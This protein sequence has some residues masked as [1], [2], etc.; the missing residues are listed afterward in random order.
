MK[1]FILTGLLALALT[2][3]GVKTQ[4]LIVEGSPG[5]PGAPGQDGISMGVDVSSVAPSCT[6]GGATIK[7]FVDSNRNGELDADEIIKKASVICN[8]IDGTSVSISTASTSLCPTGGIVLTAGLVTT[9]IC[10]G[11]K[12]DM[13]PAGANGTDGA[14][15]PQGVA[16]KSAYEIWLAAGNTGDEDDFLDS[17][18]GAD[19]QNGSNG[20]NGTNGSNGLSAY[21]IWLSLG[22]TG[23]ESQFISAITGPQGTAG[24][25]GLNGSNGTNGTNGKSAYEIWLALGNTGTEAQF[26]ASLK[27][28]TG[29]TG[30]TGPQ[31]PQ[32]VSGSVGNITP[33]QLCPGDTA[34]FKEY[35]MIV[36]TDLYAVYFDKNQ[37]IAFL[38]KLNPGSYVTTNGSNCQFTYANNGTTLTLSNSSGTTT[39]NLNSSSGGGGS[40]SFQG[41]SFEIGYCGADK[42]ILKVPTTG[43]PTINDVAMTSA[44]TNSFQHSAAGCNYQLNNSTSNVNFHFNGCNL[45]NLGNLS[46]GNSDIQNQTCYG[47]RLQ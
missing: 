22:N 28:A 25:N 7:S 26:I 20:T 24:Q 40:G 35:G 41:K 27:G 11:E 36:G 9:Q 19:G 38:A 31:G 3:C 37:P 17:L 44:G 18:I 6:A 47:K 33:V 43:I 15:G 29:S 12:G 10:N 14:A 34:T 16:G 39:V 1:Q 45:N 8:G 42:I 5:T 30:A 23:S 4:E 13:G 32:G 46:V 2:G 21:Q